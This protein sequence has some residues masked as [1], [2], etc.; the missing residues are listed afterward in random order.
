[1]VKVL[2]QSTHQRG[3]LGI[4]NVVSRA[5]GPHVGHELVQVAVVDTGKQVVLDLHVET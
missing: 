5:D 2:D 3:G 4:G 1:M